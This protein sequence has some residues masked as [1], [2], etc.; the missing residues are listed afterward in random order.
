MW[1]FPLCALSV[2]K[3]QTVVHINEELK[4]AKAAKAAIDALSMATP[5]SAV[6]V[7]LVKANNAA[8]SK[9]SR[10]RALN[11]ARANVGIGLSHLIHGR[12]PPT[13]QSIDKA[14]LAIEAWIRELEASPA[15]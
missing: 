13:L 11:E 7:T 5:K 3:C 14:K 4:A 2:L 15:A 12:G 1:L 6:L 9:L 8:I 10:G